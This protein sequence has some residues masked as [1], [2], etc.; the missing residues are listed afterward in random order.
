MMTVAADKQATE[1]RVA[2]PSDPKPHIDALSATKTATPT[3]AFSVINDAATTQREINKIKN[4]NKYIRMYHPWSS[5]TDGGLYDDHYYLLLIISVYVYLVLPAPYISLL[6][7]D[8]NAIYHPSLIIYYSSTH[9][10]LF[11]H[12]FIFSSTHFFTLDG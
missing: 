3:L 5:L 10:I 6:M 2:A 9:F 12:I 7:A 8:A 4:K 1:R 11:I